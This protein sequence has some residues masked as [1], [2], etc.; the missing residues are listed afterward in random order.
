LAASRVYFKQWVG[1][2]KDIGE[3]NGQERGNGS[4]SGQID[5]RDAKAM[6]VLDKTVKMLVVTGGNSNI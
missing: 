4:T 5:S 3:E 6:H 1:P 2:E